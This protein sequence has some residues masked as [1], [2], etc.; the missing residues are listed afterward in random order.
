M[1]DCSGDQWQTQPHLIIIGL[2]YVH[3]YLYS[4]LLRSLSFV[5]IIIITTTN[6]SIYIT[7]RP[8]WLLLLIIIIVIII[9]IIIAISN[10]DIITGILMSGL[11]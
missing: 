2:Y 4:L 9:I 5:I 3:Q 1:S 7:F 8:P 11:E 10:D 6:T